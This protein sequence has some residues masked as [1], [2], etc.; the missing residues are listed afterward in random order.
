[1]KEKLE[2]LVRE[3]KEEIGIEGEVKVKLKKFK[4]KLAS[5]SLSKKVI[6]INSELVKK[7]SDKEI[8]YLIA[9]ELLHLKH[10]VFHTA[11]FQQELSELCEEDLYLSI[12]EKHRRDFI[13]V[14]SLKSPANLLK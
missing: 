10:G 2:E 12:V 6:Y 11:K 4:I 8:R 13:S 5:V 14:L 9:H 1:M 3:L 7:L